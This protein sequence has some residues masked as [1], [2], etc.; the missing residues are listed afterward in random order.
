LGYKQ[1]TAETAARQTIA[2]ILMDTFFVIRSLSIIK[3]VILL[4]WL[5]W[6]YNHT[7]STTFSGDVAV[8]TTFT[9]KAK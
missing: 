5:W 8:G 1:R 3:R 4:L 6:L 9:A 7:V 2:F